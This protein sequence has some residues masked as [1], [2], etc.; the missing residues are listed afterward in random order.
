MS[1]SLLHASG[2]SHAFDGNQ[3]LDEVEL[4]LAPGRLLVVLGPNGSGKT[5]LVR[6]ASGV[7]APHRGSVEVAGRSLASLSRRAVARALAVVPQDT[8]MPFPYRVR[9][10]VAMGRAPHLGA[11]GREQARDREI[12]DAALS[13]LDLQA[14]AE[15]A[16]P[17]L[18]GGER[19]RVLLARAVA[20]DTG[21][22]L[23]DEPTA[24]MDLGYRMQTFEWLRRWIAREPGRGTVWVTHDLVLAARYADELLL[25][26]RGRVVAR[27]GPHS[28]LTPERIASVYGV[29]AEVA[30][31]ASGHLGITPLR[32]VDGS[33]AAEG[34]SC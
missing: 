3:V 18:S 9:E 10:L 32:A 26:D 2:V 19:Q 14:L 29:E 22:L 6:I 24:H 28:V 23:L 27:G 15:R 33:G 5:T 21:A 20:Q 11:L 12:V 8:P 16:F 4:E 34:R 30:V 17:T 1:E 25:L 13:E 31:D 7:L